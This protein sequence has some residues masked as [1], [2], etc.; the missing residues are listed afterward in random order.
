MR[1]RWKR[2]PAWSFWTLQGVST[3]YRPLKFKWR[4]VVPMPSA[5]YRNLKLVTVPPLTTQGVKAYTAW[6]R[7]AIEANM[8]PGQRGL[9]ICRKDLARHGNVPCERHA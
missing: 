7:A 4:D 3:A 2:N 8:Q 6:M 5:I 1:Q 9:V